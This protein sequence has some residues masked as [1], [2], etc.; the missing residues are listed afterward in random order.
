[1]YFHKGRITS[2]STGEC[3]TVCGVL[4]GLSLMWRSL[5]SRAFKSCRMPPAG[6]AECKLARRRGH[7]NKSPVS[8]SGFE[9]AK[10]SAAD[11]PEEGGSHAHH[12]S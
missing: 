5:F 9:L 6:N 1:M 10:H 11:A 2:S 3:T 4:I 12:R 8:H 7:E